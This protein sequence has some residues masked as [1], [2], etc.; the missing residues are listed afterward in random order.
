MAKILVDYGDKKRLAKTFGVS[1]VTI[2]SALAYR[3]KSELSERIR[4]AALQ[5][6][7]KEKNK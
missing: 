1:E 4:K 2:R 6:G 3:T 5:L 7:G